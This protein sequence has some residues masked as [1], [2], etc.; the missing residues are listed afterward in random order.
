V[1]ERIRNVERP[2]EHIIDHFGD[3]SFQSIICTGTDFKLINFGLHH[4]QPTQWLL[5]HSTHLSQHLCTY[6]HIV[7]FVCCFIYYF[8]CISFAIR[9]SGRKVAIKLIDWLTTYA[10][11]KETIHKISEHKMNLIK[12]AAKHTEKEQGI[13]REDRRSFAVVSFDI[14]SGKGSG[15]PNCI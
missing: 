13:K 7:C 5:T 1:S 10:E 8:N 11:Q 6:M 9:L 3:E 12:T 4:Y 2:H 14:R 15:W